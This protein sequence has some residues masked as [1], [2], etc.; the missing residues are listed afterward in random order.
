MRRDRR[1]GRLLVLISVVLVLG[2][3]GGVACAAVMSTTSNDSNNWTTDTD[4]TPPT[5][6]SVIAQAGSTAGGSIRQGATYHVYANVTDSGNPAAGVATVRANLA[7][8]TTGETSVSLSTA[9]GPWTIGGTS[10]SYRSAALTADD[11]LSGGTKN[12]TL[13]MTDSHSPPNSA[14][15]T[16]SVT[17][18]NSHPTAVDIQIVNG[19]GITGKPDA[20]DVVTF[21]F[22]EPMSPSSILAGWSGAATTVT[23]NLENNG[24]STSD[25]LTV[26]GANLG[27]VCLGRG[28]FVNGNRNFTTSTMVMSGNSVIVTLGGTALTLTAAGAGTMSWTPST[29]AT[30]VVG[31][32]CSASAAN[33]SGAADID[34]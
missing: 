15:P 18:D 12:Y 8:I 6:A 20:G 29:A 22:S 5:G 1:R 2:M 9:A 14:A 3:A 31:N 23:V 4:W 16:F 34:F 10:Y 21:T 26:T 11:P 30:D 13:T 33:E 32:P 24:C 19:A 17:V 28:D 7:S 25:T 27:T